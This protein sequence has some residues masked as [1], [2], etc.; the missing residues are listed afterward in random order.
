MRKAQNHRDHTDPDLDSEHWYQFCGSGLACIR[1]D[2]SRLDP[3]PGPGGQK[4][5]TKI[6]KNSEISCFFLSAGCS[7]LGAEGFSCS[8]D[9]L[10]GDFG[11]NKLQF[12]I[13]KLSFFSTVKFSN[14]WSSKTLDTEL[15]PDPH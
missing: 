8:L 14:F 15:N 9:V 7:L 11:M 2:F 3:D 4:L 6:E 1:I 12:L 10:H 13:Q 5:P